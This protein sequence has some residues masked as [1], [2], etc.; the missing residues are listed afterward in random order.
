MDSVPALKTKL[1]CITPIRSCSGS[2][3]TLNEVG[4]ASG[5]GILKSAS[6]NEI[7][8]LCAATDFIIDCQ[9]ERSVTRHISLLELH[10]TLAIRRPSARLELSGMLGLAARD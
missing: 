3:V 9:E 1:E 8:L 5:Y 4:L 6:Y 2:A 7:D 10:L